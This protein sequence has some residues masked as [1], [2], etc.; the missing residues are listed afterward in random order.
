MSDGKTTIE[1][2]IVRAGKNFVAKQT[3]KLGI[4]RIPFATAH[5]A[6]AWIIAQVAYVQAE[7]PEF[8]F[9]DG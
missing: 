5:L 9:I 3:D 7:M 1:W 8:K 6:G 4:H 2:T